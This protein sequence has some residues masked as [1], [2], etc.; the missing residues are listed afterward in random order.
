VLWARS[1]GRMDMMF[2]SVREIPKSSRHWR[3]QLE[4]M[5]AIV[6]LKEQQQSSAKSLFWQCLGG[7]AENALKFAGSLLG[8]ILIDCTNPLK[9]DYCGL[10]IGGTTSAAEI[11][12]SLAPDAKVVKAFH[13]TFA[14][15]M[16]SE[17]RMFGSI[18]PIGFYF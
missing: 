13:T 6:F 4:R 16:Q 9:P 1:G 14:A 8:K 17:S 3:N 11:V 10:A 18:N 15:L 12:A 7:R 2:D 5:Q